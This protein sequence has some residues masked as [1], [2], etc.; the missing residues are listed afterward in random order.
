[1]EGYSQVVFTKKFDIFQ[2]F[3]MGE[4]STDKGG[5]DML[6]WIGC[7]VNNFYM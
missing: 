4:N 2:V 6:F 3:N 5:N 1:M 7:D